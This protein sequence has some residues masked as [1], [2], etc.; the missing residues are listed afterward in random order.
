V[1]THRRDKS[2]RYR[3]TGLT[4]IP[5]NDLTFDQDGT[6]VS[7]V[8]YFKCQYNH[9]LKCIHW[10]CLQAGS[11]SRP[12]YLPMEV[13][14][15]LEGQRYSRKLNERQVTSI[16]RMACERPTQRQNSILEVV[17]RN[18]YGNDYC[19]KEFGIKVTNQLALVDA[20]VLPA[21]RLKYHDSGREK[22]CNPLI[23]QWNMNNKVL[24]VLFLSELH[25]YSTAPSFSFC[26]GEI[27][28][29]CLLAILLATTFI[30]Y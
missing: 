25:F 6:R 13:C 26:F 5:L 24:G 19:A 22:V 14:N 8:Q 20:R 11:D 9:C 28:I 4:A 18:N 10:P 30:T 16:L 23:G 21:P 2:V 17:S 1:A 29:P 15:I 3:I 7:V 12:I 27:L